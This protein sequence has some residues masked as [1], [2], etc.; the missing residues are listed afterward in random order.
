MD[1][2]LADL[3]WHYHGAYVVSHPE[4]DLWLAQRTDDHTTL[5]AGT[6]DE[7]FTLIRADYARKPVPRAPRSLAP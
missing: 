7:L 2:D 6:P 1:S 3:R 4:P 5:K